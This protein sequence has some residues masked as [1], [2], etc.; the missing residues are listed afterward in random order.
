MK[1]I[2]LVALAVCIGLFI[3]IL[4][5]GL[6]RAEGYKVQTSKAQLPETKSFI[7]WDKSNRKIIKENTNQYGFLLS[8]ILKINDST[9]NYVSPTIVS[10]PSAFDICFNVTVDS[11]DLE[12]MDRFDVDLP[13]NWTVTEVFTTT[14]TGCAATSIAGVESNQVVYWQIDGSIPSGCG[15]WDNGTYDFCAAV[16]IPSCT[17]APWSFPWN[18]IGDG[19]GDSPH[20]VSS[21]TDPVSC[22]TAG[23]SIT[24][25]TLNLE[26]CHT[27]VQTHTLN[28]ANDT[29]VDGIFNITYSVSSGNSH[30]PG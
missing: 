20:E 23:L 19:Y 6:V 21:T 22:Q 2:S 9:V 27:S 30:R 8:G 24:P 16:D 10:A 28:L 29:G 25:S 13:D 26:G 18:I 17:G 14:P 11:P 3:V 15:A 7:K 5:V 12:Y 4:S 1:K